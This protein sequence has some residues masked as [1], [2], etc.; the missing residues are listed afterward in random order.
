M[1]IE[2]HGTTTNAARPEP[3]DK[4]LSRRPGVPMF[5]KEPPMASP[6]PLPQQEGGGRVLVGPE[7]FELTPVFS[8]AVPPRGLSG[9][10][11]RGA[12]RI[13]EHKAARW[14]WL[15]LADRIDVAESAVRRNPLL[16]LGLLGALGIFLLRR[17]R[18]RA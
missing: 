2:L 5:A 7:V 16:G 6:P 14:L 15:M 3:V 8:T 1:T 18:A 11:R 4:D 12:Y 17:R 13:P 10:V 9:I